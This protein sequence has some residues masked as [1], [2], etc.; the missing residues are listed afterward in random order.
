MFTDTE[1]VARRCSIKKMFL[2]ILENSQQNTC[3]IVSFL[4]KETLAQ[5]FFCEFCKISKN[6]LSYKTPT[7]AASADSIFTKNGYKLRTLTGKK[8]P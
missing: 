3:A 1:A 4:I 2:E 6:T 8:Q 7:V 5:V